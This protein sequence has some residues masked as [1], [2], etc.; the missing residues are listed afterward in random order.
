MR[1]P[2]AHIRNPLKTQ[3]KIISDMSVYTA[4]R[5]RYKHTTGR[6]HRTARRTAPRPA[7]FPRLSRNEYS[8][9]A[10]PPR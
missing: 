2:L 9:Q 5:H 7:L 8:Q 6:E 4:K 3:D 10:S 1:N